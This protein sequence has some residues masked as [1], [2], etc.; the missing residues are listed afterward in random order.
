V[1]GFEMDRLTPFRAE[2]VYYDHRVL[3]RDAAAGTIDV[4]L[5]V[6]RREIVDARLAQMRELGVSVQGVQVRED[7]P[8][9]G[10]AL[11]VLP[12]GQRGEREKPQERRLKQG[13]SPARS[14]LLLARSRS[15]L[16]KNRE[17]HA[18]GPALDKAATEAR[19]TDR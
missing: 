10:P 1:L 2:E 3:G 16:R 18:I 15:R 14:L 4:L 11:D 13:L 12:T 19:A 8:R 17:V 9:A 5:A 6:A 7:A